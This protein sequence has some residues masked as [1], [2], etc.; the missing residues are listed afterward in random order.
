MRYYFRLR[1]ILLF[2]F[3]VT[4]G[5]I[6]APL[7]VAQCFHGQP[8]GLIGSG[9]LSGHSSVGGPGRGDGLGIDVHDGYA[10]VGDWGPFQGVFQIFDVANPCDPQLIPTSARLLTQEIGDVAV[11]D[12][13]AF[14]ANDANGIAIY[15]VSDPTNPAFLT[16]R[17]DGVYA[18]S[19]YYEGGQYAYVGYNWQVSHLAIYDVAGLPSV[20][21]PAPTLYDVRGNQV[22]DVEVAGNRAYVVSQFGPCGTSNQIFCVEIVDITVPTSPSYISHVELNHLVYGLMGE[23]RVAGDYLYLAAGPAGGP[24]GLR[25]I[26]ISDELNPS[27]VGSIDFADSGAMFAKSWGLAVDR[28]RV[29]LAAPSGLYIIDVSDPTQPQQVG[30]YPWPT[31]F[32][33]ARGGHVEV[34]ENLAYAAVYREE[35]DPPSVSFGGVAI[36]KL[37]DID[38]YSC[39]GFEPPMNSPPVSVRKKRALPLKVQ[40]FDADGELVTDTNI[41]AAPVLQVVF[42]PEIG[43]PSDVTDDAIAVGLGTEGNQFEYTDNNKWQYNLKTSN[44]SAPGTYTISII[45]GDSYI[46]EPGCETSFVIN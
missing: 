35:S 26:D 5:S 38:I 43:D 10:Y 2:I 42:S 36:Y 40:L 16:S 13:I 9:F 17:R 28:D 7:A 46:I 20:P 21:L 39:V 30:Q 19:I 44:Y 8:N 37:F 23:M 12:N 41:A 25:V 34:R 11:H 6:T 3:I 4:V 45:S 15:D 32:G 1:R 14:L 33:N 29:L 24:G 22:I 27:L 31:E 18:H